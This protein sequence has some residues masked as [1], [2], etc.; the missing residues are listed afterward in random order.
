MKL[1][2]FCHQPRWAI[3]LAIL[4][5]AVILGGAC[6]TS[7]V[8][9][10]SSER[11]APVIRYLTAQQ[12]VAPSS[13]SQI[14]CVATGKDDD[15]LSY[16]WSATKGQIQGEGGNAVWIAPGTTGDYT[17][18]VVVSD[19]KGNNTTSSVNI[20]VTL[21][22]NCP[23]VVSSMECLDCSNGIEASRGDQYTIKCYAS[24]PEG[25]KL[26]YTWRATIG[27][28]E[29]EFD[30]TYVIFHTL[31]EDGNALITVIVTDEEGNE[32]EGYLAINISC[33]H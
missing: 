15:V 13:S 9:P 4:A 18:T 26:N 20:T 31:G 7:T 16:K 12:Q 33:C 3:V 25:G 28:I 11:N 8:P 17:V 14:L 32:T 24:D 19:R 30:G 22:P 2:R 21:N 23:P 27:K 10:S 1:V 6:T 29:D 5:T